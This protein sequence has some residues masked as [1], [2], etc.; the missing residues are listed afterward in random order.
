MLLK[1]LLIIAVSG[2]LAATFALRWTDFSPNAAVVA[3]DTITQTTA[4]I[5][6]P[7]AK[8]PPE[9]IETLAQHG[10][11][12]ADHHVTQ[13]DATTAIAAETD[14]QWQ[15]VGI[16]QA[17]QQQHVLLMDENQ[18]VA[19]LG[20]GE[21]QDGMTLSK[22]HADFAEFLIANETKTLKLYDELTGF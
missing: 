22:I 10:F 20:I 4:T 7:T 1:P 13:E 12:G 8:P 21:Q 11:W 5:Q 2:L 18:Q 9:A 6:T 14:R 15:L 17:A 3:S 16:V 19:R